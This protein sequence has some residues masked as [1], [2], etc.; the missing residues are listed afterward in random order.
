MN[1]SIS[2]LILP[3]ILFATEQ[4]AAQATRLE[5]DHFYIA[6]APGAPEEIAALRAAG[7]TVGKRVN[8]HEGQ[9]TASVA[10]L[11]NNIYLELIWVE[12]SVGLDPEHASFVHWLH[13]AADWRTSNRTPFGMGLRR[14]AGDTSQLSVRVT[15]DSAAYME[16]GSVLELLHQ[17]SDTAAADFFVIPTKNALPNRIAR[18]RTNSPELLQH[19]G[20]FLTVT[21]VRIYGRAEHKPS[22]FDVLHPSGV[23]FV[24]GNEPL[25]EVH[26]EGAAG[27]RVDLRPT[28][29]LVLIR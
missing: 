8:R 22:V 2:T 6:T 21:R 14:V 18:V 13:R 10:V 29:P 9:G 26:F 28:L 19:N 12:S 23:E 1:R 16:P 20:S 15:R 17:A 5:L 27:Q 11:F 3:A 4:L 25:A 24:Y 7:L